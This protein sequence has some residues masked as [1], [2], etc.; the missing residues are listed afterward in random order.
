MKIRVWIKK[1]N[2]ESEQLADKKYYLSFT[3]QERLE[4]FQELRERI[5]K[6]KNYEGR[7]G[8]RRVSDC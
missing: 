6:I 3:Q 2:I 5:Y 7:K 1:V 4:M 8:L